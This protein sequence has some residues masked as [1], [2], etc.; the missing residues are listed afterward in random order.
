MA[1]RADLPDWPRGLSEQEA[2]AYVGVGVT[3]FRQEVDA[4]LWPQPERRGKKGGR[5]VWDREEIDLAWN[6]RKKLNDKPDP[7]LERARAWAR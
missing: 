6:R 5:K 4:G 3:T 7:L 2:A 1:L